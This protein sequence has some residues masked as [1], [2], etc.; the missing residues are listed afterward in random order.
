LADSAGSAR[1]AARLAYCLSRLAV[2]DIGVIL[3]GSMIFVQG[4]SLLIEFWQ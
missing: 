4:N 3:A 2:K 1:R